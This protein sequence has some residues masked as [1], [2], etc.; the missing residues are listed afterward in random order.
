MFK[1]LVVDCA[2]DRY[3]SG[4]CETRKNRLHRGEMRVAPK[5][6]SRPARD[7]FWVLPQIEM[8][9]PI[10]R[11]RQFLAENFDVPEA[12]FIGIYVQK[13]FVIFGNDAFWNVDGNEK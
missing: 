10:S 7:G 4:F 11:E 5:R 13:N 8:N 2:S 1:R 6:R 9:F 12:N 3:L